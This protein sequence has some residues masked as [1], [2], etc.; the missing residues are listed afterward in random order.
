MFE[1][2]RAAF[3]AGT[4]TMMPLLLAIFPFGLVIGVISADVGLSA[5]QG[6]GMSVIVFAGVSQLVALELL[7]T[8]AVLWVIVLS[9][10]MVNLRHIIYSA[11]LAAHF[12]PLSIRWKLLLSYL[13]VDQTYAL[14]IAHYDKYPDESYKPW[15]YFGLGGLAWVVWIGAVII[16]FFVGTVIPSSWSL[17]FV[18]PI[19][20]LGLT[21]NAIK[22][23]PYLAA[24]VVGATVAVMGLNL[25][26]NL[27]L[28]TAIVSG[29]I[30]GALL[31]REP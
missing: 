2:P 5:A 20:F 22:G 23:W 18:V 16:G 6:I 30:T 1:S 27:G 7:N 19:M 3:I 21:V 13:L 26:H 31:E 15:Y 29:I 10:A 4:Q 8:D 28:V 14:S 11:S 24:A 9:A 12:K 17:N 25:P